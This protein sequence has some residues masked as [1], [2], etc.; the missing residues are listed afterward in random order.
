MT[1]FK[2]PFGIPEQG[3]IDFSLNSNPDPNPN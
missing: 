1:T 3:Q 2:N